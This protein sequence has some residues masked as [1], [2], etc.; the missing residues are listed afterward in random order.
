MKYKFND[1][2]FILLSSLTISEK[3]SFKFYITRFRN[4]K[5]SKFMILFDLLINKNQYDENYIIKNFHISKS[6]LCNI[7]LYL[8]KQL[9]ISLR[10]QKLKFDVYSKI[11]ELF[12]FAYILYNKGFIKDAMYYLSKAKHVSKSINSFIIL[13]QLLYFQKY[14][15]YQCL[16]STHMKYDYINTYY[17]ICNNIK[18]EYYLYNIYIKLYNLFLIKGHV[19]NK[20]DR[21]FMGMVYYKYLSHINISKLFF[22]HKL[23]FYENLYFYYYVIRNFIMS[24]III[25]HLIKLLK[26]YFNKS[27]QKSIYLYTRS[28]Y[29][30]LNNLFYLKKT[31]FFKK[32]LFVYNS[33]CKSYNMIFN[34]K[35]KNLIFLYKSIS[36]I[37][38]Y[39]IQGAY[40][41]ALKYI[42]YFKIVQYVRW[43]Y[44]FL[45]KN[46]LMI[47]YYKLACLYFNSG[48]YNLC[49]RYLHI[50]MKFTQNST[51]IRLDI[52]CFI[53]LLYLFSCHEVGLDSNFSYKI[54]SVYYFLSKINYLGDFQNIIIEYFRQIENTYPYQLRLKLIQ[55]YKTLILYEKNNFVKLF[56][57]DVN[58]IHWIRSKINNISLEL[59]IKR[60]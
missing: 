50:I 16:Y 45:D 43:N 30:L 37:N 24:Y 20:N 10:L 6:K 55:L 13:I 48:Y 21:L 33:F 28:Y 7:K 53:R 3:R 58:I 8:Y 51:L 46:L 15:E 29:Y 32:I 18:K 23:I 1:K 14:I 57:M 12:D 4:R 56:F 31:F 19:I 44:I 35:I 54:T 5:K 9:L 17:N 39:F 38:M 25:N 36:F 59:L 41:K 26:L 52:Q 40:S 2:L 11:R 49:I 42:S 34:S 60:I 22:Y 47:L 27:K